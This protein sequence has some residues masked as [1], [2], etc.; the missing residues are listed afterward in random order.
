MKKI[1]MIHEW[2]IHGIAKG[3]CDHQIHYAKAKSTSW[4]HVRDTVCFLVEAYPMF[5]EC[6]FDQESTDTTFRS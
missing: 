3:L 4:E 2:R 1:S 6:R 5:D